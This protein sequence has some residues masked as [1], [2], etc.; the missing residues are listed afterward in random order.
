MYGRSGNARVYRY[1]KRKYIENKTNLEKY[2]VILPKS[3]GSGVLGEV[4]SMPLVGAPLI[5]TTQTFITIGAFNTREE[6][7]S[8]LKYIKTKFARTMLGVLKITQDNKKAVWKYVP[9]QDFTENSDIDWSQSIAD[10]DRQLY[11]KYQLTSQEIDF[12]ESHVKA[13]T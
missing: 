7:E 1:V 9:L 3:N 13:M 6:A 12:I 5:G 2:K 8:A 4:L 11:Q 10:I